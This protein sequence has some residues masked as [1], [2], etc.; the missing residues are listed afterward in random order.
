[1]QDLKLQKYF[2]LENHDL[3]FKQ[4]ITPKSCG[5]GEEFKLLALLGDRL[6]NLELFE[7]LTLEGIQD[8][9]TMTKHINNYNHNED[10]LTIVGR[11]LKIEDLIVLSSGDFKR[12]VIR[13]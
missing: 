1:M 8:S 9:G 13:I 4:A 7:I 11:S 2:N 5:G 12:E 3:L 6:L 10:I